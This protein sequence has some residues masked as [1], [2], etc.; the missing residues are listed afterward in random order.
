[1]EIEGRFKDAVWFGI[2]I[3]IILG[4]VGGIGSW[5]AL[6]VSRLKYNLFIYDFDTIE[7]HNIGTQFYS[8][9]QG[10][11]HREKVPSV[12]NNCIQ[13][14][15][16]PNKITGFDSKFDE[17]S[18]GGPIMISGFDNMLSRKIFFSKWKEYVLENKGNGE[19]KIF[20]DGR[21]SAET[22]Q[23]F[24]VKTMKDIEI[25]EKTL[26][27]DSEV[28]DGP[29][30]YKAT[31]HNGPLIGSLISSGLINMVYNHTINESI[32][33]VP[34]AIDFSIAEFRVKN[35]DRE[36]FHKQFNK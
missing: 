4:G 19:L 17:N 2:P 12:R 27:D 23:I 1:M 15:A 36:E 9:V 21:M 29:C 30:S 32:R 13:F 8:V 3:D 11:E 18:F 10:I 28:K 33:E 6:I 7:Q 20:I 25:Y 22:G 24:F 31:P 14:G 35:Y 5:V 34:F 16:D 26:F